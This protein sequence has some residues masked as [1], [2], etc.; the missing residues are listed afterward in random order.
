MPIQISFSILA[1]EQK[2]SF[3]KEY[4]GLAKH[5]SRLKDE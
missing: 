5:F 4:P 3:I 1:Q 2:R